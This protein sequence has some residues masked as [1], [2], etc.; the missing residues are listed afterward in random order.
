VPDKLGVYNDALTTHLKTRPFRTLSDARS[1]RRA[2]DAVWA[3]ALEWMLNE[4]MWNFAARTEQWM[5]S[6]TVESE[7]GYRFLYEK[8]DDYVR[9]IKI[10]DNE[11]LNPTLDDFSE[12]T[13]YFAAW[14]DPIYVQY[15]SDSFDYGADPGKWA[16]SFAAAFSAEMAWRAEGGVKPLSS[17]DKDALMKV[18]RRLLQNAQSKDVVNQPQAQLPPGRLVQ[19]R[20][21]RGN[22]N[23][24][25]RTP[26][27]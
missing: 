22:Y 3:G 17:V 21:G 9:L 15:V 2:L 4:G 26:Y 16:P 27:A 14:V 8:P 18:K 23:R 10:S 1:E 19:S 20:G 24:M 12:E 11:N 6:D 5:P 25:R 13:D 7:F